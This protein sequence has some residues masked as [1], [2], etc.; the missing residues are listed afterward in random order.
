MITH[1][2]KTLRILIIDDLEADRLLARSAL[3]RMRHRF[4]FELHEAASLADGLRSAAANPPDVVL[5]DLMLPDSRGSDTVARVR[6]N[7]DAAIV[8]LTVM[9]DEEMAIETLGVGAHEYLLKSELRAHSLDRAITYAIERRMLE[10]RMLQTQRMDAVGKLAGGIAHDFNNLLTIIVGNVGI[11]QEDEREPAKVHALQEITSAAD[12]AARL[13]RQLLS[14]ARRQIIKPEIV[15]VNRVIQDLRP[16]LKGVLG[17]A[18]DLVEH[19]SAQPATVFTDC[20]QLEQA[21]LNLALNARDAT[22]RRG[23][24]T[25]ST[26]VMEVREPRMHPRLAPDQYV[27]ISVSDSGSGMSEETR[28]RAFEPFFTT[29]E[30]GQGAGLGLAMVYGFVKQTGGDVE[31]QS[32]R[33]AG[34]TVRLFLPVRSRGPDPAPMQGARSARRTVLVVED[35]DGIRHLLARVLSRGGFQVLTAS[36]GREALDLIAGA[37]DELGL[38]ICDVVMPV[39][40]GREFAQRFRQIRRDVPFIFISGYNTEVLEQEGVYSPNAELINKPFEMDELLRRV[41]HLI[42]PDFNS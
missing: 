30:T 6:A 25:I 35:E 42:D 20:T 37:E 27:V 18:V 1:V 5:L 16:I 4:A 2:T 34:T 40:G 39:M 12:R 26:E 15:D 7:V 9:T 8:V 36:N 31:I 38:I 32:S 33:A 10:Q 21:L 29:K 41:R 3:E 22:D 13:T 23:T 28:R 14:F 19:L 11:L 17:E 24:C